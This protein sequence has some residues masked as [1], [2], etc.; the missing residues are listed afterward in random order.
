MSLSPLALETVAT[1]LAVTGDSSNTGLIPNANIVFGGSGGNRTVTLSPAINQSGSAI[2]TI[3][4]ND[5]STNANTSFLVTVNAVNSPP[6][7]SAITNRVTNEET[8]IT[9]PFTIG[10]NETAATNLIVSAGSSNTNLVAVTNLVFG[11]S[12]ANR[13]V[14]I[15]PSTN[16]F[17]TSTVTVSVSDGITSANASFL[18]TVNPVNDAPIFTPVSTQIVNEETTLLV[19]NFAS[20]VDVPVNTLTFSSVSIP[21]GANLTSSGL[22]SWAPTEAQGPFTYVVFIRVTDDGVPNLSSTNSFTIIVN[23][24]NKA[25]VFS[26]LPDVS[27]SPGTLFV[28]TNS[29]VD[30]DLPENTVT[31]SLLTAL[32]GAA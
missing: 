19:T 26:P 23:E 21:T 1:S 27:I 29:A 5:G 6:T 10:D 12:G 20:D 25:P 4:V 15:L 9:I 32:P 31:Y 24:V 2:I 13:T 30:T 22:F 3:F 28:V 16:Q 11:G 7:I 8:P 17:G 14:T 18:L